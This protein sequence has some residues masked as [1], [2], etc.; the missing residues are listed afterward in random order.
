MLTSTLPVT[1]RVGTSVQCVNAQ[2]IAYFKYVGCS[3]M[4]FEHDEIENLRGSPCNF[5]CDVEIFFVFLSRK[6]VFFK[7]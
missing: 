7:L 5:L 6:N 4:L 1:S 2:N 3:F